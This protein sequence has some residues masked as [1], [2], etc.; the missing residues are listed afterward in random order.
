MNINIVLLLAVMH[1]NVLV[2]E[3]YVAHE[4]DTLKTVIVGGI[5][6]RN[7]IDFYSRSI[8]KIQ[9]GIDNIVK[10]LEARNINAYYLDTIK[11]IIKPIDY[12]KIQSE[13]DN[14][15]TIL[16]AHN[17][18]IYH[19]ND[20]K[21]AKTVN[22]ISALYPRDP[23]IIIGNCVIECSMKAYTRRDEG[24]VMNTE[25][26]SM[27]MQERA[28]YI[29]MP[30]YKYPN[31]YHQDDYLLEGGNVLIN[32]NELYAGSLKV[33]LDNFEKSILAF[34]L[35]LKKLT[36]INLYGYTLAPF[37]SAKAIEWLKDIFKNQYNIHEIKIESD[38]YLDLDQCLAL[39]RPGLGIICREVIANELPDS[40]KNWDFIEISIDELQ[41]SAANILSLDENT[42]IIDERNK[43]VAQEL[44]NRGITVIE[45]P[46]SEIGKY[47]GGLR[48]FHQ[49]LLRKN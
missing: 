23:L 27:F 31:A 30:R 20:F 8:N 40:I 2:G 44:R 19:Y 9:N 48:C 35:S 38:F 1:M 12:D 4:W 49:A 41:T 18:E 13:I 5:I 22:K 34:L 10:T 14:V 43:R 46:F 39:V 6:K 29:T 16:K 26:L 28:H 24:Y 33:R 42:I 3:I 11:E 15:V 36:S 7:N 17:V 37:A 45:V 47:Q 32:G 25:L 21:H